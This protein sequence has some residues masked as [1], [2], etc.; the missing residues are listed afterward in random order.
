MT[1]RTMEKN[2]KGKGV[3]SLENRLYFHIGSLGNVPP[4]K[5]ASE[6]SFQA[7]SPAHISIHKYKAQSLCQE[8]SI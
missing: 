2:R 4:K 6:Y 5:V 3:L 8:H 7:A 1:A